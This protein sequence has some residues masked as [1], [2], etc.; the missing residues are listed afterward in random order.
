MHANIKSNT[1][2]AYST[3]QDTLDVQH[4]VLQ[5]AAVLQYMPSTGAT[6]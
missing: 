6:V 4:F 5:Q 1:I 3:L 2:Q